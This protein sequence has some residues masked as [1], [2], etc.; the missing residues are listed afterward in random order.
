MSN[1]RFFV[2]VF[3][4]LSTFID[5]IKPL[6]ENDGRLNVSFFQ[7]SPQNHSKDQEDDNSQK[8]KQINNPIINPIPLREGSSDALNDNEEYNKNK[9]IDENVHTKEQNQYW[10]NHGEGHDTGQNVEHN[11]DQGKNTSDQGDEQHKDTSNQIGDTPSHTNEEHKRETGHGEG[12]TSQ[13]NEEHKHETGQGED[14]TSQ[15]DEEHKNETTQGEDTTSQRDEEHKNE[16]TQGEDAS[17]QRNEEH[18][19]ETG[20]GEDTAYHRD[21]EH[22]DETTQGEDTT[23]QKNEQNKNETT[24]G[25]DASNQRNE[26]HKNETGQGEDTAYH[27]D[28]EHK[29]VTTQGENTFDYRNEQHKNETTQGEDTA[30]HRD[31]EHKD[32][33]TQGENTFD[34]RNEQH[35]NET[36]QGENTF[37]YRN[38]QHKNET[39]QGEDTAYHRDEEHKDVTTQ[40]EDTFGYRNEQ[41]KDVTTQGE[42]TTEQ[43]NDYYNFNTDDNNYGNNEK[44]TQNNN[45]Q[46]NTENLSNTSSDESHNGY[47]DNEENGKTSSEDSS[48]ENNMH[49]FSGATNLHENRDALKLDMFNGKGIYTSIKER[50]ILEIMKCAGDGITGLLRLKENDDAKHI[51]EEALTKLNINEEQLI[52]NPNLLSLEMYDKILSAMFKIM[53]DMSFYE[54]PNFYES[55]GINKSILNQSLKELKIK[56]LKKI[57]VIYSK[58]PPIIKEKKQS[59]P[60]KDYIVSITSRELAQRMAIMFTKWLSPEEYGSVIDTSNNI[61]LNVLCAGSSILIQQHKYFQNVLGFELDYDHAY[62]SLIDELLAIDKRYNKNEEYSKMLK[63]IKK[64]KVFNYCTKIM[65][66]GGNVSSVP[67]KHENVKKPSTSLVGSLGNLVKAHMNTYYTAIA[68]RINSYYHYIEKKNKKSSHLK[69]ISVCTLLHLTDILYKCSDEH[70]KNVFDFFNLQLNTLNIEGKKILKPLV[71]L[72]FL[73]NEKYSHLKEICEP[74]NNVVDETLAKL[75]VLLSTE[76]HD[77]LANELEKKGLDEDYVKEEI[78]NINED[79]E[80]VNEQGEEEVENLV[81]EDL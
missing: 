69:I 45:Q 46:E 28:E 3:L 38:E 49:K 74:T 75:L 51:F 55:M 59:C 1:I 66:I 56:M 41:H 57:G 40:G 48:V 72:D 20:Q 16:T 71:E 33:T 11:I 80:N 25:E 27:R 6:K 60:V 65:R 52:S 78:K 54:N 32:V 63:K 58:L 15:R 2:C 26:E 13:R 62:L 24:Q 50:T 64:S 70:T 35:K 19:N 30:Y 36:T 81:F 9:N 76:S 8:D 47:K 12:T 21:E 18:K 79:G 7:A 42:D 14:T 5:K 67:F 37:D 53:T 44:S 68:K 4:V 29:D 34:Y 22:K 77:L 73:N 10:D 39:T 43:R 17:N 31:E 61:E 23:S